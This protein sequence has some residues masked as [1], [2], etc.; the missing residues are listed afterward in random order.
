MSDR[1]KIEV[2]YS[3]FIDQQCRE[4]LNEIIEAMTKIS[5]PEKSCYHTIFINQEGTLTICVNDSPISSAHCARRQ[6]LLSI[7]TPNIIISIIEKLTELWQD[8]LVKRTD[9]AKTAGKCLASL[10]Q[11]LKENWTLLIV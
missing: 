3:S 2:I 6:I 5:L 8:E 1:T 9:Q 11:A 7:L 4:K 10:E